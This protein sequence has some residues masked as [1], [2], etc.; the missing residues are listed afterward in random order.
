MDVYNKL[1]NIREVTDDMKLVYKPT[2][3]NLQNDND[4]KEVMKLIDSG[5]IVHVIDTYADQLK[6]VN[7]VKNPNTLSSDNFSIGESEQQ[8]CVKGVWV[9]YQWRNCLVHILDENEYTT[10]RISRNQ[11]LI[12]KTEQEQYANSRIGFAGLNVGNP[13]A[14]SIVLEGG[15]RHMKFA[16]FDS[17]SVSNLNRFRSGVPELGINK[18]I[19]S[20]RQAFEIDPFMNIDLF[21]H[22]LNSE[23]IDEF[24]VN[25]RLLIEEMDDLKLKILIREKAKLYR[26]PV[27]MVTGDGILD[28]ERYDV[29]SSLPI[30][31]GNIDPNVVQKIQ[32]LDPSKV[33]VN[34]K[35]MLAKD[36]IGSQFLSARLI[37]SFNEIGHTIPSIPQLSE[38]T[39][40]RGAIL[41]YAARQ[42]L[43]G[44]DF[45]SGRYVF[46]LDQIKGNKF[47][48]IDVE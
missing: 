41:T 11:N 20:A 25:P 42:I 9:Y 31:A 45:P 15:S 24:L 36:F 17:L 37:K 48:P 39:F 33:T 21:N 2:I 43:S 16:D 13:G 6:E 18:V 47:I 29:D 1:K 28:V 19:I 38:W 22:G 44:G 12:S 34:E 35:V 8:L 26:I 32:Q 7:V 30:L 14:I 23:N 27:I 4:V 40:L 3:F 10:L 46:S 5:K